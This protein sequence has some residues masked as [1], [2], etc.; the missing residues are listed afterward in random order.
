M[1]PLS[2]PLTALSPT[3]D[4]KQPPFV[5]SSEERKRSQSVAAAATAAGIAAKCKWPS[6]PPSPTADRGQVVVRSTQ[7]ERE[8]EEL[9]NF[10]PFPLAAAPF[11]GKE[12]Y[13]DY[14]TS[15]ARR[16]YWSSK[17]RLSPHQL[18]RSRTRSTSTEIRRAEAENERTAL[19]TMT[20][21]FAHCRSCP[22]NSPSRS[23]PPSSFARTTRRRRRGRTARWPPLPMCKRGRSGRGRASGRRAAARSLGNITHPPRGQ[24][25]NDTVPLSLLVG[26]TLL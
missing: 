25:D 13:Q 16:G 10:L 4:R 15:R 14:N 22:D 19:S 3:T 23:L 5:R 17:R 1:G 21:S 18:C 6:L 11:E 26:S 7:V 20:N 8:R 2:S 12:R 24:T 9:T